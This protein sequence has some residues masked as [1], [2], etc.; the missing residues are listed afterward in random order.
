M[1]GAIEGY[2]LG[3]T[4]GS[5]APRTID[6]ALPVKLRKLAG[7]V[8]L[9]T[10]RYLGGGQIERIATARAVRVMERLEKVG[11]TM[12]EAAEKQGAAAAKAVSP[13][14][15]AV[16]EHP[17]DIVCRY[18]VRALDGDPL[19]DPTEWVDDTHPDALRFVALGVLAA[20]GL[21]AESETDRGEGSGDSSAA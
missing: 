7:G 9:V 5:W 13:Q 16:A 19:H 18:V 14:D 2:R 15:K 12:M 4:V 3:V 17:P 8:K 1:V 21:V 6:V 11:A 20:S 10:C